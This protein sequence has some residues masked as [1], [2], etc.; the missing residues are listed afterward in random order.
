M[1][2]LEKPQQDDRVICVYHINKEHTDCVGCIPD[3]INN[4][5]CP[6]YHPVSTHQF[7]AIEQGRVPIWYYLQEQRWEDDGG[8]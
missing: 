4:P 7:R 8:R 2:D 3:P 5:T 6:N 1:N